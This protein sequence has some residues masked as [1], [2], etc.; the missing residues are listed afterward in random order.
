VTG[1]IAGQESGN[2]AWV[3]NH[4]AGA[5]A[6]EPERV[7]ELVSEWLQPGNP[8]LAT[9]AERARAIARPDAAA[10]IAQLALDMWRR[11]LGL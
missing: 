11:N 5:F 2:V 1:F 4:G 8:T 3:E 6:Q 7:A 10:E 9:M